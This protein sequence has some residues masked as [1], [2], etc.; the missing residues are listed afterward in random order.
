M[1]VPVFLLILLGLLEFG[2][3]FDHAMTIN[4]ATREGARSGA[5]FA[6]GNTTTMIC[7]PPTVA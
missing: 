6:P 2:F 3:V 7:N 1:L 4:Y 5:A